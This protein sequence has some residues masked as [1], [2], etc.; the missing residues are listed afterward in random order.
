MNKSWSILLAGLML[1]LPVAVAMAEYQSKGKRDPLVPLLNVEGQRIYPP[2]LD[3]GSVTG[4]S[5]LVLQGVMFDPAGESFAVINGR[6]IREKEEIQGMKVVKIF[7]SSV[8]ILADGQEHE[9]NIRKLG[10]KPT[11]ERSEP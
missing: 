4:I 3:E 9:L 11:E 2:G 6:M 7:P 5:G 8:R 1:G 10:G